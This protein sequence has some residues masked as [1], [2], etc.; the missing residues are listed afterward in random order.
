MLFRSHPA[1]VERLQELTADPRQAD[2]LLERWLRRFA[3]VAD[4][5][6]RRTLLST[7][8]D[9]T[10]DGSFLGTLLRLD[11][12]AAAGDSA[13]RALAAELALTPSVL[14]ELPYERTGDLYAAAR[15]AGQ[16]HLALRFL[17]KRQEGDALEPRNPHLELSP[18]ERRAAARGTD[19]LVL[20]RLL[21]DRDPRVVATLLDNPRKIGRAHV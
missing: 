18:G 4:R 15:A 13:C 16:D 7:L 21:H 5:D 19:R 6:L 9:E 2:L 8:L 1:V 14:H 10:D 20:D 3:A 17:G 11:G 12:R